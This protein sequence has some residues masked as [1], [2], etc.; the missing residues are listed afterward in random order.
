MG[1][2]YLTPSLKMAIILAYSTF[3]AWIGKPKMDLAIR[4]APLLGPLTAAIVAVL[5]WY[6]AHR[7]NAARDRINKR[8]DLITTYLLEAYRRLET[9]AN[10]AP[11]TDEQA[12]AFESAVADIQLLGSLDQIA[13]LI[14]YL[15]LYTANGEGDLHPVLSLL[16]NDLRKELALAPVKAPPKVFRFVRH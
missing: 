5:G 7:S 4:L 15:E 9:A 6:V 3:A 14:E 8:R 10:R 12:I 13:A 2:I 11:R 16:R 1:L